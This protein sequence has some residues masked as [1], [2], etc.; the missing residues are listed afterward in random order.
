[1]VTAEELSLSLSH[2]FSKT[3]RSH[4]RNAATNKAQSIIVLLLASDI[5]D[6]STGGWEGE[7]LKMC[8]CTI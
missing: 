1:M 7:K 2:P 6:P 4:L 8:L 5:E 3:V